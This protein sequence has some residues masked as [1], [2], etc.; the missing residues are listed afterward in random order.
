MNV[1]DKAGVLMGKEDKEDFEEQRLGDSTYHNKEKAI[2]EWTDTRAKGVANRMGYRQVPWVGLIYV[3]LIIQMLLA[4][5]SQ[6]ARKDFLVITGC[7][8]GIYF[9]EFPEAVR[10][11][12]FR[13]LV[14]LFVLSMIYD[15]S[16]EV[17][18]ND[19]AEDDSGGV[20]Q[21]VKRFSTLM[22]YISFVWRVSNFHKF[23][24]SFFL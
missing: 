10:R 3:C 23:T 21:D 16:W 12:S 11:R 22:F 4:M 18:N 1:S 15:I 9:M 8:I 20:E 19:I 6:Y 14:L 2:E 17:M 13:G 7:C 5:F 24:I